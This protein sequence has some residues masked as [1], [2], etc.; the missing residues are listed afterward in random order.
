MPLRS[1]PALASQAF[2]NSVRSVP[3][4]GPGTREAPSP[5]PTTL[6]AAPRVAVLAAPGSP[7]PQLARLLAGAGF[8]CLGFDTGWQVVNGSAGPAYDVLLIDHG[9]P[10]MPAIEVIRAVRAGLGRT[11]S[12]VLVSA[13]CNEDDHVE[14]LDAGADDYLGLPLSPRVLLARIAALRRRQL[15]PVLRPGGPV[16]AGRYELNSVGRY[17]TL[18]GNMMRL[19]PKEF[20]LAHLLFLNA[21]RVL[22][23]ASIEQAVWGHPLP[24]LSRALAGLVSRMR[25]SLR[26]CE[27]N[28]V[29]I[30]VVYAQGYRLDVHE[31][32]ADPANA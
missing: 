13:D 4:S 1:A 2:A 25:R 9:L 16:R 8:D 24:P 14:A 10:D 21:G 7:L 11:L 18:R 29:S 20:D 32:P 3:P 12:I 28:G 27:E 19:T 22:S 17:A 30:S 6:A 5:L 15:S 23:N 26:L 31:Y